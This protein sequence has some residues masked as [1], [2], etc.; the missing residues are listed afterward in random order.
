MEQ[1][2]VL[3]PVRVAGVGW[4]QTVTRGGCC[5]TVVTFEVPRGEKEVNPLQ[6]EIRQRKPLFLINPLF[7]GIFG[8]F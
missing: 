4:L 5:K 3:V 2:R 1:A 6:V 7:I 8:V